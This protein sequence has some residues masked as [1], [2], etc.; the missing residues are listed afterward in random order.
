[1]KECELP[2]CTSL[3]IGVHSSTTV[4]PGVLLSEIADLKD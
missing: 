3:A 4:L 1:M 2:V